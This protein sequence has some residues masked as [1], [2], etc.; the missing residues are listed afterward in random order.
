M[1]ASARS[2]IAA[3]LAAARDG[4]GGVLGVVVA[5]DGS[6]YAK[7]G[8]LLSLGSATRAGWISG[9]CLEPALEAE[10]L[11]IEHES[12]ARLI[13]YDTRDEMDLLFG[14]RIGCRGLLRVALLPLGILPGI[15]RLLSAWL[16][17]DD[18]LQISANHQGVTL[19]C[20]EEIQRWPL[21]WQVDDDEAAAHDWDVVV[22]SAPRVLVF[23]AG[24]E[25]ASLLSLLRDLGARID[26]VER[27][28]RWSAEATRADRWI[29]QTPANARQHIADLP[30]NAVLVMNHEFELDRESLH[31]LATTTLP[32]IGLLGPP[33]RRDDLLALLAATESDALRTRLHAPVDLPLGG[34]G[35]AAIALSIAAQLQTLWADGER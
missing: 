12:I 3:L 31:M 26:L 1:S 22:A 11:R 24:P 23:G 20:G 34:R 7:A 33:R 9:G 2:V 35:P 10:A 29:E 30:Y 32:W 19:R 4:A 21:D 6:T 17:G 27:R 8:A 16:S 15:D 25:T 5:T 18:A 13:D 14:S 28:P